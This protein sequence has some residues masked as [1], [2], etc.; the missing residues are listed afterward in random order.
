MSYERTTAA[1]QKALSAMLSGPSGSKCTPVSQPFDMPLNAVKQE[2]EATEEED[3][4]KASKEVV[5]P[6]AMLSGPCGSKYTPSGQPFNMPLNGV[7]LKGE[8]TEEEDD[9]KASKVATVPDDT[10]QGLKQEAEEMLKKLQF[11]HM[12]SCTF[13]ISFN[14]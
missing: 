1:Q 7:K 6:G 5:V 4:V 10:Q 3:V 9:A 11:S 2:E 12:T 8:A 13:N 14:A